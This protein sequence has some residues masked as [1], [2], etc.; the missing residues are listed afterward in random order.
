MTQFIKVTLTSKMPQTLYLNA[1]Y[2][3]C[4][5]PA[6]QWE[7]PHTLIRVKDSS[8]TPTDYR[9]QAYH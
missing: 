5:F 9:D 4:I 7:K 1:D 6:N 2:V 8:S 3:I